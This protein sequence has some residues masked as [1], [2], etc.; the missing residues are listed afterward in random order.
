MLIL[1]LRWERKRTRKLR[2]Y[3]GCRVLDLELI[4]FGWFG[5]GRG[6]ILKENNRT[7]MR[8]YSSLLQPLVTLGV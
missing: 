4:S 2:N 8:I 3:V 1:V 5:N 7:T 6:L